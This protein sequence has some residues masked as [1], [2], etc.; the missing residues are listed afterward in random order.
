MIRSI[1][2]DLRH[3]VRT[4]S[5]RPGFH[6]AAILTLTLGIGANVTVFSMLNALL[7]RPLPFGERS[8]RVVTLFSTHSQQPE[9]WSWG[10]SEVSYRDLQD[11]RETEGLDALGGY[12]ARNFTLSGDDAA[13]RVRGGSV[14][15]DLFPLLGIEPVAGRHFRPDEA[16]PPGLE[17]VVMLTHGL[18]Q[19]RYGA[20]PDIVGQDVVVNG[21]PRTVIGVLPPGFRFPERDDLYLPLALD[22]TPR[23]ARNVNA[24]GLLAPG[25]TL[26]QVQE[27]LS[28]VASRLERE[29]PESNRGYGV[30]VQS[31]RDSN[32]GAEE[33]TMS[34]TLMA[35]VGFVLLIACANLTNLMLV[36]GAGRQREMAV[37]SA[38]GAG[39]GRLIRQLLIEAAILTAAGAGLGLLVS[40]W[41]LDFIQQ[42][43][44]EDLPYWIT[45]DVD[46]RVA[47]FSAALLVLTTLAVGLVPALRASRPNLSAD[48]KEG[49]RHTASRRQ[50][51]LQGALVVSQVALCLALLVGANLMIRSFLALQ[52]EGLGFD[53]RPVVSMRAYLAGDG[54]DPIEARAR[55]FEAMAAALAAL[56]GV[57]TAAAT[58]SIPGDD[59]GA[60]VRVVIDGRAGPDEAVPAS[61]IGASA[62]FFDTLGVTLLAGRGLTDAEVRDSEA[63]VT[64]VN[65]ALA[66]RLWPDGSAL[67]RRLG[68][69][70]AGEVSWY[71]VVGIAPDIHYE[72][73]GEATDQSRL[74]MYVPSAAMGYR[75]MALLARTSGPAAALVNPARALMAQRFPG[76]PVYEVM[77]MNE[78]RRF[79]T[80]EQQFFGEMMGAFALLAVALACLGVYALIAYGARQRLAEVGVRLALGAAPRDV[81]AL[82]MRRGLVIAGL[83]LA[84]GAVLALGMVR[85]LGGVLY[86]VDAQSVSHL[87]SAAAALLAAVLLASYLPARRASRTDPSIALRVG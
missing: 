39:R 74:T 22:E 5:G 23:S 70:T 7:L 71:R 56:P 34:I 63:R 83:G 27:Q 45:F 10:E 41:A 53:H 82:F 30:R 72:E 87:A 21:L 47:A 26:V 50:Q 40:V 9:H 18:W 86:G 44:P 52:T 31:F 12:L 48:L 65:D 75:T 32:I 25:V 42:S 11:L 61:T 57:E 77:T 78:R 80:W 60:G 66:R 2:L 51:R 28:A 3:A 81:V 46:A 54:F 15:P 55:S 79:V 20:R 17:R 49:G 19:R 1:L 29:Y 62:S 35:A 64:V 14:T 68:V 8:D 37:R 43:F 73:V 16:A 13:E 24:V 76:V 36:R 33:R 6:A 85:L 67:D 4:L 38:M 84:V 69:R 58:T 59:G